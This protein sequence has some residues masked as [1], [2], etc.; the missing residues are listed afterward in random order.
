MCEASVVRVLVAQ[1]AAPLDVGAHRPP[2][3]KKQ[4]RNY[5]RC[6]SVIDNVRSRRE[7]RWLHV[8]FYLPSASLTADL[9]PINA[10]IVQ[11]RNAIVCTRK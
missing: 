2:R 5:R 7:S 4:A 10:T 8:L 3:P 1:K 11:K 9:T 6:F